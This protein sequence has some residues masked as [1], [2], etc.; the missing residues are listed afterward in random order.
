MIRDL[1]PYVIAALGGGG[2][3]GAVIALLKLRPEAG[4]ITVVAA[5]GALVV[6][7]GVLDNVLNEN[8]RLRDQV[9]ALETENR[10]LR[11]RLILLERR[12]D[13][14]ENGG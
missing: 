9:D 3:F 4:Q 14:L 13:K 2:L 11:A 6:Q 7:Q 10:E 5:Q 1:A 12:L 8:K